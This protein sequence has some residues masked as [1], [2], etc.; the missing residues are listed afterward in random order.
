MSLL[1]G[2]ECEIK[3]RWC[4]SLG[5]LDVGSSNGCTELQLRNGNVGNVAFCCLVHL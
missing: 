1:V 5:V 4:F 2:P 3:E